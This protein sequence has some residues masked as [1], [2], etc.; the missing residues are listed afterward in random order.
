M[1]DIVIDKIV[2]DG[3]RKKTARELAE[4]IKKFLAE[5]HLSEDW[6]GPIYFIDIPLSTNIYFERCLAFMRF[7]NTLQHRDFVERFNGRIDFRG[8]RLT[9]KLSSQAPQKHE[10]YYLENNIAWLNNRANQTE[11]STPKLSSF[12]ISM[13]ASDGNE[14]N[15]KPTEL[16]ALKKEKS[17]LIEQNKKQADQIKKQTEQFNELAKENN[18]IKAEMEKMKKQL[19]HIRQIFQ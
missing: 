8:N 10:K 17:V 19:Q 9:L 2:F 13:R 16:E 15:N 18:K 4:R 12:V 7:K 5:L 14:R 1:N 3:D 11:Q 6:Y